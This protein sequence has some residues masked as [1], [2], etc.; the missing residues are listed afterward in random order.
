MTPQRSL[1]LGVVAVAA[2]LGDTLLALGMKHLGPVS[3]THLGTL[4]H[5][6]LTPYVAAGIA[7]LI[8]FF[9]SYLTALSWAD[10]TYILPTTSIGNVVIALLAHFWLHE[11]LTPW[12]WLGIALITL[13]VG[14]VARGDSYTDAEPSP[15]FQAMV[16][17]RDGLKEHEATP[18]AAPEAAP[19]VTRV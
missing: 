16:Q 11:Q 13:G 1:V 2:P 10:L 15:T 5:A 9:A 18:E 14:F 8:T 12:R 7:L 17:P 4:V 6:V 3:I 19:E